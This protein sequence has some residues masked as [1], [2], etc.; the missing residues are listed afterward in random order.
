MLLDF[1]GQPL[2]MSSLSVELRE[3]AIEFVSPGTSKVNVSPSGNGIN[4]YCVV[5]TICAYNVHAS[6]TLPSLLQPFLN[7]YQ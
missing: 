5:H 4:L 2:G 7:C 3:L 6:A 1:T